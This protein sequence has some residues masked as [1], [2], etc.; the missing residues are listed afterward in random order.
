MVAS[1]L[2]QHQWLSFFVFLFHVVTFFW[3]RGMKRTQEGWKFSPKVGFL[4]RILQ[5]ESFAT[6]M[7]MEKAVHFSLKACSYAFVVAENRLVCSSCWLK[8]THSIICVWFQE[9]PGNLLQQDMEFLHWITLVLAFQMV[10]MA[11]SRVLKV[12]LMM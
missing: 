9:L 1:E 4:N 8:K 6:V 2:Q 7:A 11:T 12:S 3:D 5:K 10:F